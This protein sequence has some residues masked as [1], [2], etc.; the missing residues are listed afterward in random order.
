MGPEARAE[1]QEAQRIVPRAGRKSVGP[2]AARLVSSSSGFTLLEMIL[3]LFLLGGVLALV[4]P[5]MVAGENLSA[6]GRHFIGALRS[7]QTMA[8]AGQTPLKIYVDLDNGT[9]WTMV[10]EGKEEK[11]PTDARWWEPRTLPEPIRFADVTVGTN[12]RVAGRIDFSIYPNGR[13]DPLTVHLVDGTNAVLGIVVESLTG[14]IKTSD[15]RIEPPRN[16]PLPDRVTILLQPPQSPT[17]ASLG[18]RF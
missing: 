12:K 7:W 2:P 10:L 6:S 4:V 15:E 13:I 11:R 9:Y 5:R 17:P 8:V 18:L 1:R 16:P 3:V 14:A